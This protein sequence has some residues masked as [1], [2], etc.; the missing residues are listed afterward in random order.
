MPETAFEATAP[1]SAAQAVQCKC[2]GCGEPF[3]AG[4]RGLGKK[5]C[6]DQ[7]RKAFHRLSMV[8]GAPLLPFVKAW[9]ATRHAKPGTREAE[10][11][12]F[13]R[14]QITEI[15]RLFLDRDDEEG[16]DTVAYVGQLM[17]SGTLYID[18]AKL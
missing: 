4:G 12:T 8:E 13:A 11:C 3:A 10:I 5:F 1:V 6:A 2:P 15:A 16:R 9:H 14:G 7:C 18:R 17:D